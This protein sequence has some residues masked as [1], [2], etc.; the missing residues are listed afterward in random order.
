VNKIEADPVIIYTD[1][2]EESWTQALIEIKA[3][4]MGNG[5]GWSRDRGF[6]IELMPEGRTP[7]NVERI[8]AILNG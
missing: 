8:E 1:I 3:R 4:A 7:E 6:Y 2:D 5:Y